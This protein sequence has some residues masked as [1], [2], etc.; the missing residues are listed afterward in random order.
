VNEAAPRLESRTFPVI[1]AAPSGA[2]KSSIAQRLLGRRRD[3]R[4]SVSMTT[5]APRAGEVD[6]EDY[7]FVGSD[8]FRQRIAAGELMEWA[9]VHG[10]L[11][12]T[13]W[14]NLQQAVDAAEF[15]ILDIDIQGAR[16]VRR[17]VP[18]AVSIFVLPPSGAELATRLAGRGS[19][20]P[21]TRRRRLGNA[22]EEIRAAAEFD[23]L[24]VNDSLEAAVDQAD[25]IIHAEAARSSRIVQ[26]AGLL[27]RLDEEIAEQIRA[28]ER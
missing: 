26:L 4:F 12:G 13:P 19:E 3:M 25:A 27:S 9:E 21:G 28:L 11:Y 18:E 22:R 10:H 5:R 2:G 24:I 7:R 20:D 1:F 23:Y 8:E 14:R 17:V 16:Q 15:L 6:G